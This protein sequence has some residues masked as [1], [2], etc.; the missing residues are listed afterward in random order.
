MQSM[1]SMKSF[2]KPQAVEAVIKQP[3]KIME[4]N[5]NLEPKTP[6]NF[7]T[8]IDTEQKQE[9]ENKNNDNKRHMWSRHIRPNHLPFIKIK[10]MVTQGRIPKLLHKE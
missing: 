3:N 4:G 8:Y 2:A 7:E 6:Y 5:G 1:K 10:L 9:E